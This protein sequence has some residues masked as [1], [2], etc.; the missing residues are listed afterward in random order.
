MN[1]L[2]R[3]GQDGAI[4]ELVKEL[5]LNGKMIRA[6]TEGKSMYPCIR[7]GD[8]VTVKPVRYEEARIGDILAY[9]RDPGILTAHRLL[10]KNSYLIT[11]GDANI[12]PFYD[13]PISPEA[14]LGKIIKIERAGRVIQMEKPIYRIKGYIIAYLLIC[15]AKYLYYKGIRHVV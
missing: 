10:R 5:L 11:K 12:S 7:E 15:R 3:P 13:P 8:Y 4:M 1:E 6:R 9:E 2:V 14:L